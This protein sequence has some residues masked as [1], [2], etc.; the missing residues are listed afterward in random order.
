MIL[1]ITLLLLAISN[2]SCVAYLYYARKC[3]H[4]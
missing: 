2:L 3:G 4:L 1:K